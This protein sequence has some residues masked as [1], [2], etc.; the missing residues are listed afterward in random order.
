[1]ESKNIIGYVLIALI[2]GSTL[3]YFSTKQPSQP[4]DVQKEA[5]DVIVKTDKGDIAISL[6][7][8]KAPI[9]AGNF[10]KLA[11]DGF[12]NNVKFHRVISG[13]MIQAGDPNTK[14]D[15]TASYGQGGPGYT[16]ADEFTNGLT[17]TRGTI[18]MANTGAPHSSGSQFFINLVDNAF[19]NG[20]YSVFGH[21][22]S[23]MDVVDAIGKTQT[24]N[25]Q[26]VT[27]IV[28]QSV[29]IVKK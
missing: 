5:A 26:P 9:S 3:Y 12:Y 6:D 29:E 4:M 22:V 28:I 8:A 1:M 16:I 10:L 23:G 24:N 7:M 17:N 11:Q 27:P 18:S 21:V 20:G 2:A 25:E 19:L 13:F 15:N 14:T